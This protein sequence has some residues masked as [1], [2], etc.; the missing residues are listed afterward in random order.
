MI[1]RLGMLI[2]PGGKAAGSRWPCSANI[3][4]AGAFRA[5]RSAP[6]CQLAGRVELD[7]AV[8]RHQRGTETD[9][10]GE[11]G[12]QSGYRSGRMGGG[13]SRLANGRYWHL[14]G[15]IKQASSGE[16]AGSGRFIIL[17]V[18]AVFATAKRG[19]NERSVRG[20]AK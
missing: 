12:E 9:R 6:G 13:G 14:R 2:A 7:G 4:A 16:T 17:A 8:R 19:N 15:A 18:R 11:L 3:P 20:R 5:T 1:N 10:A